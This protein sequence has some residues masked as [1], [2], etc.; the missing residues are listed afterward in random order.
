M[1][2]KIYKIPQENV[3]GCITFSIKIS[4]SVFLLGESHFMF[5]K[6][7]YI[8]LVKGQI[9]VWLGLKRECIVGYSEYISAL[10]RV[11]SGVTLGSDAYQ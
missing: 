3:F 2:N 4:T 11:A 7:V 10:F 6:C 9:R 5:V 8:E 1:W